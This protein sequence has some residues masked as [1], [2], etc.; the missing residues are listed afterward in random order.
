M[1]VT[2]KKAPRMRGVPTRFA[3]ISRVVGVHVRAETRLRVHVRA[4]TRLR[5]HVR[6]EGRLRIHVRAEGRLRVHVRAESRL[7]RHRGPLTW[8]LGKTLLDVRGR[9]LS[10]ALSGTRID[11]GL[12]VLC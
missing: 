3:E 11:S 9:F 8:S 4:Q 1:T 5:V 2:K 6:A 7:L 12:L 10:R